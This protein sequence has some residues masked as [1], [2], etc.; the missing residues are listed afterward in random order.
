MMKSWLYLLFFFLLFTPY[1]HVCA[2]QPDNE[3]S[4]QKQFINPPAQY[5]MVPFFWWTGEPLNIDRIKWELDQLKGNGFSGVSI[6]YT[7]TNLGHSY[8]GSP[9]L[10]SDKWW[11]FWEDVVSECAKRDMAIGYDDY[12]VTHGNPELATIGSQILL[13]NPE[14]SSLVIRQNGITAGQ[15]K[16][17]SLRDAPADSIVSIVAYRSDQNGLNTLSKIDLLSL[18]KKG[19]V[20]W[21]V[22]DGNWYIS[23]LYTGRLPY[24]VLNP[25]YAKNVI[26]AYFDKFDQHSKGQMGKAVNFFFQDELSFGGTMPYWSK[27]LPERFL[28]QKGY[29]IIPELTALFTDIGPRTPKIRLDYYDVA[30]GIMEDAYF[31]PI[32]DWTQKRNMIYGHD[33]SARAD[34]ITGVQLYGDYFRT[35]RW[36][37]A[38]GTDRMPELIRGKVCASIAQLYDRPRVWLEAYHSAGWG[39]TPED[40]H[41]WDCEALMYGYNL[42]S[43]HSLY[44]TTRAGWWDWAPGDVHFR[45]PYWSGMKKHYIQMQRMCYLLSQGKHR[46]DVAILFPSST[47]QADMK[48]TIPGNYAEKSREIL[49][50]T[51][52]MFKEHSIDFDYIDDESIANAVVKDGK[53]EVA[54][55]EYRVL[56]LPEIKSIRSKTMEKA[57]EFYRSGGVLIALDAIPA[58]SDRKGSDDKV[59]DAGVKEIFGITSSEYNS[60]SQNLIHSNKNSA[61]GHGYIFEVP[62]WSGN[63]A[64]DNF[65]PLTASDIET[66]SVNVVNSIDQTVEKDFICRG[67]NL[68]VLHRHIGDLDVYTIYNPYPKDISQAFSFRIT[69]KK[70]SLWDAWNGSIKPIRNYTDT[71]KR[72]DIELKFEPYEMKVIGFSNDV[73]VATGTIAIDYKSYDDKISQRIPLDGIWDFTVE[74]ILN[75][76]WGDFKSP[77]KN[78]LIGPESRSFSYNEERPGMDVSKWSAPEL[79][80]NS[81][82][83]ETAS[84]GPRFWVI[85]PIP[86]DF[87][88]SD[89]EKELCGPGNIDTAKPL[90]I[91]GKKLYWQTYEYSLRWGIQNDPLLTNQTGIAIHGPIGWVPD[92]FIHLPCDSAGDSWYISTSIVSPEDLN[93]RM[94]V[95]TRAAFKVWFDGKQLLT[96][97]QAKPEIH[98]GPW[99]FRVYPPDGVLTS[100]INIKKGN[101][102][103]LVKFTGDGEKTIIR[104][105]IEFGK[106]LT[107]SPEPSLKD[108][109]SGNSSYVPEG[110]VA[111][112]WYTMPSKTRF[113]IYGINMPSALWYR[114]PTPPGMISM[115]IIAHGQPRV[116][117]DGT[118][119]PAELADSENSPATEYEQAKIYKI[120]SV[121]PFRKSSIA[122]IRIEPISGY[123][124]G[125]ALPEPVRFKCITGATELVDWSAIGLGTYSG[126]ACYHKRV[127]LDENQVKE[128]IVLNLNDVA[129]LA[130]IRVNGQN[131]GTCIHRPWKIDI[132]DF[133]KQGENSIDIVVSNTLANHYSIG[134]PCGNRYIFGNQLRAGMFGPVEIE[135]YSKRL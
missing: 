72:T 103:F 84:W 114:F 49:K 69:G 3:L 70:P 44:Y 47:V 124:G 115:T 120:N 19:A 101:H 38:P 36:F 77:P 22:P 63:K 39:V 132:T 133:V 73:N 46:C 10:F 79:N 83:K 91:G 129:A 85:G 60:Q 118:E 127:T 113:D 12:I 34:V 53:L 26:S 82:K 66:L 100:E 41:K 29:D 59:L 32:Y 65:T 57:L 90:I 78:E 30:T 56:M 131:A 52:P 37:Q 51:D 88:A 25:L 45:Q 11:T 119:F 20:E 68:Y 116:W 1:S 9:P 23:T 123:Y 99:N 2:V 50:A 108:I 24:G 62:S 54:G 86:R 71:K 134:M 126:T 94:A 104:S 48:G 76:L 117:V 18:A 15:G 81:W 89:L 93:T 8:K 92:E 122:A 61:G 67:E 21:T 16:K 97:E 42:L 7:H 96:K 111:T 5:G 109:P 110:L 14:S 13:N 4:I 40:L 95:G 107:D 33:Q 128:R 58:S 87:A 130:D 106:D 102:P 121:K 135:L 31:K 35:L 75:N 17:I 6:N 55:G 112:K 28:K 27:E 80:D 64:E 74:P 98:S 43:Y 105:F 125:A